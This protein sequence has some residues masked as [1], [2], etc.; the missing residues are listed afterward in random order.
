MKDMQEEFEEL[1]DNFREEQSEEF[2]TIKKELDEA[3]KNCRL[4]QFKLRKVEKRADQLEA[5]KNELES[6]VDS[7]KNTEKVAR[8]EQELAK[9]KAEHDKVLKD[10]VKSKGSLSPNVM[11][12]KSPV[13]T[14]APSGEVCADQFFQILHSLQMSALMPLSLFSSLAN[15][16]FQQISILVNY[17]GT[18]S[19]L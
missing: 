14:K 8:L 12:K 3:S 19:P 9:L 7:A 4:L 13:L 11:K 16:P 18:C 5:E 1:Q 17:Y 10:S 6:R 15:L 2:A